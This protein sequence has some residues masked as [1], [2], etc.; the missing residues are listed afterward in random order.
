MNITALKQCVFLKSFGYLC[1]H[2]EVLDSLLVNAF[3]IKQTFG[4]EI[5]L[6]LIFYSRF[7]RMQKHQNK[8]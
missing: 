3:Y 5:V 4:K 2:L 7:L 8:F 6:L 1:Y